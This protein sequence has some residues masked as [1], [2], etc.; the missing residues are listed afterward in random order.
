M[1]CFWARSRFKHMSDRPSGHPRARDDVLFRQVDDEWV[2]FD[3]AA[4]ELHVLNL[5]A[6]IIWRHCTGQLSPEEIAERLTEAYSIEAERAL[7]DVRTTL[8]RFEEAG[9][10]AG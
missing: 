3:P 5:P 4:N 10:L 8:S 7:D 6:A 2:V 9:L 1:R